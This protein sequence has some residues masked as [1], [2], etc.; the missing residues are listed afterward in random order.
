MESGEVVFRRMTWSG[1]LSRR[2]VLA[3]AGVGGA[4]GLLQAP[5]V[6]GASAAGWCWCTDYVANAYGLPRTYPNAQDWANGWLSGQGFRRV[7]EP[8]PWA[9]V[10]FSGRY[11][12]MSAV[13]HVALA[14]RWS[15]ASTGWRLTIRGANQYANS[16]NVWSEQGCTNVSDWTLANP[17]PFDSP[18]VSYW[19]R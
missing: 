14:A 18:Y 12:G 9:I 11:P 13:G 1:R 2:R 7:G 8:A 17:V 4:V 3:L 6:P 5:P 10:V 15:R 16:G 19:V